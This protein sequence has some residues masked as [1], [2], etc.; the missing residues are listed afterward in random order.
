MD[1]LSQQVLAAGGG[2]DCGHQFGDEHFAFT[3]GDDI[4]EQRERFGVDEGDGAADQ[5]ERMAWRSFFRVG[6]HPRQAEHGDD[7]G[8]V[9][10][11]GDG[12]G[13]DVEVGDGGS[14]IRG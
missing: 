12:E 10:L 11:E 1:E 5:D 2:G 8:V 6:G 7:V 4:S 9:P 3:G 14:G 13:E